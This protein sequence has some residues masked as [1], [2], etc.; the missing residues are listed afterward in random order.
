MAEDFVGE[1]EEKSMHDLL[2][3]IGRTIDQG[4]GDRLAGRREAAI[5]VGRMKLNAELIAAM[6]KLSRRAHWLTW[7]AA[8]AGFIQAG[9]AIILLTR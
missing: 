5:L 3:Q 1:L 2:M 4:Q 8:G 7:V 9:A 6:E